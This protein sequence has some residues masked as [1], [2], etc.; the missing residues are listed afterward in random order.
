M[1]RHFL[2]LCRANLWLQS[3]RAVQ[4]M[5]H[6]NHFLGPCQTES[7][8]LPV[9]VPHHLDDCPVAAPPKKKT[10]RIKFFLHRCGPEKTKKVTK[11]DH[12]HGQK[13]ED[14]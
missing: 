12:L 7:W 5:T 14:C 4:A 10:R 9:D 11:D 13:V 3:S 2:G 1:P 8:P 6:V